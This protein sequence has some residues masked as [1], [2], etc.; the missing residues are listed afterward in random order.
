MLASSSSA[1]GLY[2][3]TCLLHSEQQRP[4]RMRLPATARPLSLASRRPCSTLLPAPAG[5]PQPPSTSAACSATRAG[6]MHTV[7]SEEAAAAIAKLERKQLLKQQRAAEQMTQL[8]RAQVLQW[9]IDH[10]ASSEDNFTFVNT[11][12]YSPGSQDSLLGPGPSPG[13]VV[14]SRDESMARLVPTILRNA[15]RG[16]GTCIASFLEARVRHRGAGD[17]DDDNGEYDVDGVGTGLYGGVGSEGSRAFR[18]ALSRQLH[19]LTG[20]RPRWVAGRCKGEADAYASPYSHCDFC[21][22]SV[23]LDL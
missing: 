9:A 22:Y 18:R 19:G 10:V 12:Y 21:P 1:A 15:M 17:E 20:I 6:A 4:A 16:R 8:M 23:F 7:T 13:P 11:L 5:Q 14:L 3:K 2:S